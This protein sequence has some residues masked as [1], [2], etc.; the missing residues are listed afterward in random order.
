MGGRVF[1]YIAGAYPLLVFLF[2]VILK[3]P[4]R[5]FSLFCAVFGAVYFLAGVVKKRRPDPGAKFPAGALRLL[6]GSA[7]FL[8]IGLVC[9]VTDSALF[10][11]LYPVFISI[12][13]L[14]AF[15]YT[16][17][18]PPEMIFRFAA[19]RDKSVTGSAGEK[20]VRAYCRK[21]TLVWCG[22]FIV[23]G[24]IALG[25]VFGSDALWTVYNG[26]ISYILMGLLFAG[27][28]MV[29]RRLKKTLSR[30]VFLSGF[31]KTARPP[32]SVVCY[33]GL[34][35]R[36]VYKTW[37]D[38]VAETA[39][40]R[41][42][43][44]KNGALRWILY[45][46]D[47]WYFLVAFIALLQC[48]K[49]VLLTPLVTPEYIGEIQAGAFLTD[50]DIPGALRIPSLLADPAEVLAGGEEV[51]EIKAGET[52]IVLYT[53]GSTGEPKAVPWRLAEM[54]KENAFI[55][56]VWGAAYREHK[57][58]ATVSHCHIY[59]LLFTVLIPFSSGTPFRRSRVVY[60]EELE[61][62]SDDSYMIITVPAFLKR[63]TETESPETLRL[64]SAWIL[65]AGGI[66]TPELAEK[67]EAL[68]GF[69]PME[70][71]GS[72]ETN[73][74][75][76]RQSKA[77]PAWT[78]H[79]GVRLSVNGEGCLVVRSPYV[80]DP[81]GV[82][83]GDLADILEDGSFIL[84]G[85]ADFIV[86]IEEKRVSL[87]EVETRLLQSGLAADVCVVVMEDRRQY[88]AAALVLN[89]EGE[90]KFRNTE[91][92]LINRYF[93]E[94]LL[95][96]FDAVVVPKKWRYLKAFPLDSQG[97]KKK[98]AIQALFTPPPTGIRP[99]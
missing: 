80:R 29:R 41:R 89:R 87:L 34:Y 16:L 75:A 55:L 50:Q 14:S 4:V 31:S 1:F 23:N 76:Y 70:M 45:S 7:L 56:S 28:L 51:P 57:L 2:L 20:Q 88:L 24:G 97:K 83:T 66:L 52:V 27:E 6:S 47:V 26:G 79:A 94:Y 3:A 53:S 9:W 68:T 30:P 93:R 15:G 40:L 69:W 19:L 72:T 81:A 5:V 54:E 96:F 91:K 99:C 48:K 10:L 22:F 35:S 64:K 95:R 71:Y 36:G 77:G 62:F 18:F 37:K 78:P 17:F 39:L 33:E 92:R 59:G 58:C 82:V 49:H 38:L 11:K 13:L 74:I 46:E 60:P 12:L 86:K 65:S 42:A 98:A 61:R 32:E 90:L 84:K 21:V 67:T 43:I 85:R 25:T 44:Q 73:G 63:L 8:G